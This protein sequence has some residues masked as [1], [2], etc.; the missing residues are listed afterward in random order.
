MGHD[1]LCSM[2]DPTKLWIWFLK[3][4]AHNVFFSEISYSNDLD[5]WMRCVA[6]GEDRR[7]EQFMAT[8]GTLMLNIFQLNVSSS[9]RVK[10]H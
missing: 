5:D 3:K 2:K 4:Q 1:F 6:Q 9:D 8:R 7:N 10:V